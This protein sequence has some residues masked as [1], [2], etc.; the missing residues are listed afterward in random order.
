MN[1]ALGSV[2]VA[3]RLHRVD[4]GAAQA[5]GAG[6]ETL[7]SNLLAEQTQL[8]DATTQTQ[9]ATGRINPVKPDSARDASGASAHDRP[10]ASDVFGVKA[11]DVTQV[12]KDSKKIKSDSASEPGLVPDTPMVLPWFG[13]ALPVT[14]STAGSDVTTPSA[15]SAAAAAAEPTDLARP[16]INAQELMTFKPSEALTATG[17]NDG[18][19]LAPLPPQAHPGG[20]KLQPRKHESLSTAMAQPGGLFKGEPVATLRPS[21]VSAAASM[22]PLPNSLIPF[23]KPDATEQLLANGAKPVLQG[24]RDEAQPVS[25]PASAWMGSFQFEPVAGTLA[26][27]SVAPASTAEGFAEQVTSELQLWLSDVFNAADFGVQDGV[28]EPLQVRVELSGQE[29]SVHFLTDVLAE[30]DAIGGQLERLQDMLQSQGLSL[31]GTSI[32]GSAGEGPSRSDQWPTASIRALAR[33]LNGAQESSSGTHAAVM[34]ASAN[35]SG[36]RQRID[37]FV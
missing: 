22:T 16:L 6:P 2:N 32:G 8:P 17:F 29:V 4:K 18:V 5:P 31:G 27:V 34:A 14:A 30:R 10:A 33:P 12:D 20:A 15:G 11:V 13:A 28:N 19:V 25:A 35:R 7:F 21:T 37:V 36:A 9:A 3:P 26:D 24:M 1:A 23:V